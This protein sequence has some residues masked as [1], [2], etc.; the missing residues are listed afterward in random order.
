MGGLFFLR[1]DETNA[2]AATAPEPALTTPPLLS[3]NAPPSSFLENHPELTQPAQPNQPDLSLHAAPA[4]EDDS[5]APPA[6]EAPSAENPF[7]DAADQAEAL[8]QHLLVVYN[9]NDPDSRALAAYYAAARNIPVERILAISCPTS[10]EITRIE[11]EERIREPI[12]SYLCQKNLMERRSTRMQVGGLV[13]NLLTATRNDIWA[14]VL[15]RGVPLKIAPDPSDVRS[16]ESTPELQTNAAAVDSELALLPVFGLPKGGFV[17]NPFFDAKATGQSRV[18]P[19]LAKSMILVTRL[20]GPRPED[21]RRMI[22]DSLY[23][24]KNRLAG[25]AVVDSRGLT[26]VRSGYTQGDIWFRNSRDELVRDGW[27]VKFDDKNDVIPATDPCNHVALYFGWYAVDAVGPWVTPPDRFVRGAIAYHLHSFSAA[28]VRSETS[29]WV[30]PLIA[31]GAAATMGMVYE[32]YLVLTPHIDIFT[33][34][35]LAG[36]YFAEAAYASQRGLSWMGTV[37]G[38]PL[39]RPFR[40]PLESM[41]A[42]SR[43]YPTGHDDWLLLQEVQRKLAAGELVAGT[44]VL[45]QYLDGPDAGGVAAEGLGDLL[46]KLQEPSA[47]PAAEQAY[48]KAM[49][50]DT[51]PVDRIRVGVKL[52][53]HDCNH[54]RDAQAQTELDLLRDLYPVD[55]KRFGVA[56][57]LVPTSIPPV[58]VPAAPPPPP[59]APQRA[60]GPVILKIPAPP[61]PPMPPLP[62]QEPAEQ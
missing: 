50:L 21:V 41:A 22:D 33:K 42:V 25:L 14:I 32:P 2:P 4:A 40:Q 59:T 9:Q 45:K 35:L 11:Y 27:T 7:P 16:M 39:Y 46:E 15:M 19:E 10:E 31:H 17:P 43:P 36:N 6:A 37:I 3:T 26:D 5:S 56:E 53:Q 60:P 30:G 48:Q 47:I 52:A 20:D 24:E 61:K 54:G 38:D 44:D 28:T 1:A 34:R 62:H 18:G 23:A 29:H 8:P 51:E 58:Y 55:A 49:A 12:V 13:L 57:Q